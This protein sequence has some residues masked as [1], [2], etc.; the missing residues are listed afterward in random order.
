MD[1]SRDLRT[2]YRQLTMI[3]LFGCSH[4]VELDAMYIDFVLICIHERL[5]M[6]DVTQNNRPLYRVQRNPGRLPHR[7]GL[8]GVVLAFIPH[9]PGALTM[10]C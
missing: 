5:S 9:S 7:F 6:P 4:P 8:D 2:R 1:L 10:P 3:E